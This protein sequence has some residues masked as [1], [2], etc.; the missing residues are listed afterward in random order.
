MEDISK[1]INVDYELLYKKINKFEHTITNILDDLYKKFVDDFELLSPLSFIK[2]ELG[3]IKSDIRMIQVSIS[4]YELLCN[5]Y[6]RKED[7][8]E[9]YINT[10]SKKI[11]LVKDI[12]EFIN[13]DLNIVQNQVSSLINSNKLLANQ[14]SI[15]ILLSFILI[16][17]QLFYLYV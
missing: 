5:S 9:T 17:T 8:L 12:N 4:K 16:I 13:P 15:S 6:R 2:D 11:E 1:D 7:I 3:D 14:L 10:I